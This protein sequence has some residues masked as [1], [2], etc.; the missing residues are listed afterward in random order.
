MQIERAH[1]YVEKYNRKSYELILDFIHED[2]FLYC[3]NQGDYIPERHHL[4]DQFEAT[5]LVVHNCAPNRKIREGMV[6]DVAMGGL[7]ELV[8]VARHNDFDNRD[9]WQ[10]QAKIIFCEITDGTDFAQLIDNYDALATNNIPNNLYYHL[11]STRQNPPCLLKKLRSPYELRIWDVGQGSA[12]SV[13]DSENLILFDFG[14]SIYYSQ[15]QRETIIH[16]HA[17]LLDEKKQISLIISHW[18][19]DHINLL[20]DVDNNFLKN[21]GCVFYPPGIISL[22]AKQIAKR[23][24]KHCKHRLE[25]LPRTRM[26]RHKCGIQRKFS[27]SGYVLYTGEKSRDR[28]QSGL[29]LALCSKLS[30]ALLTADHTNYQVWNVMFNDV[31]SQDKILHIVVPHHGANCGRTAVQNVK[32][33]GMAVI[34]VGGNTYGHPAPVTIAAYKCAQYKVVRTDICGDDIIIH[35]R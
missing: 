35:M 34:S 12:N 3:R 24:Y 26:I 21:I 32:F 15:L 2:E 19:C 30:T 25:I 17:S 1:L 14:T 33:P 4:A 8:S 7:I 13:S 31:V 27:G 9:M 10:S 11:P 29:L 16:R 23:I 6:L 28:N 20:C 22:T 5:I 18:D